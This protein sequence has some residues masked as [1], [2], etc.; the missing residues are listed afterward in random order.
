MI[1]FF[2][3]ISLGC[4]K[5]E[6]I[7]ADDEGTISPGSQLLRGVTINMDSLIA[8]GLPVVIVNTVDGE[9]P[10]CVFVSAPEGAMGS[11]ITDATKVPC[12]LAIRNTEGVL[13]DSGPYVKNRS[14]A[15]IKI[16]GNTSAWYINGNGKMPYKIKLQKK[17]DLLFRG[18][19][20]YFDKDW[21][22][23]KYD[24][25]RS[26]AGFYVNDRLGMQW[27]PCFKHVNVVIN[28]D[29]KG[30]YM[31]MESVK[32][33]KNARIDVDEDGFI[34]EFDPYYWNEPLYVKSPYNLYPGMEYTFK[35]PDV[36]DVTSDDLDYFCKFIEE[37]ESSLQDGSYDNYIDVESFALWLLGHDILG[38]CDPAG[39]NI[40]ITKKNRLTYSKLKMGC[41]W[42]FDGIMG[43][44]GWSKE[45]TFGI[46]AYGLL[47]NSS[48]KQFI[49]TYLDK[50][51]MFKDTL[52][53]NIREFVDNYDEKEL[54][55][56]EKSLQL[57]ANRWGTHYEMPFESLLKLN[58]YFAV[59]EIFLTSSINSV[60]N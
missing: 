55:A 31:V 23:L 52:F 12:S 21:L 19:D 30:V 5:N 28:N 37:F 39:S 57:D 26:V 2:V 32:C 46:F 51:N 35:Y 17:E 44:N 13:Y 29:Y 48:N 1:C 41:L 34:F 20:D 18:A 43:E 36:D 9:E 4:S 45:H 15:T 40:F 42:D 49:N 10:T 22:L 38:S 24:N 3:F 54:I 7:P 60:F 53:A 16:R 11:S 47:L 14:G 50:W 58:N 25:L 33:N 8:I 27:T 6:I 56:I 59:K